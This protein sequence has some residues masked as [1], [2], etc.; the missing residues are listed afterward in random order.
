VISSISPA[1][2]P[3]EGGTLVTIFG[4]GFQAPMQVFFGDLEAI[5]VNV[6]NDTT[7]ANQD[8]ITC[9]APDY[10][11][12]NDVPPVTVDVRVINMNSG[13]SDS[14]SSF[15]YGDNL[16]ISGNTPTEGGPGTLL[17]I[18]GSGFEDPLHVDLLCTDNCG[19]EFRLEVVSV[20]GTEIVARIP[21]STPVTC[22]NIDVDIQVTLLDS[23]LVTI[24]GEFRYL[25]Q[26]PRIFGVSPVIFEEGAGGALTPDEMTIDGQFFNGQD[27]LTVKLGNY[28]VPSGNIE[29]TG[30]NR[31]NVQNMPDSTDI[32]TAFDQAACVTG[33]GE[34]GL[35]NTS[36]PVDITVTNLPG[37]CSDFEVA[38][39]VIEPNDTACSVI[40]LP[41]INVTF[42]GTFPDTDFGS[43]SSQSLIIANEGNAALT[44]VV[45]IDPL[46]PFF[47]TE[48]AGPPVKQV[49]INIPATTVKLDLVVVFDPPA[50][51]GASYNGT[52]SIATNDPDEGLI[53]E[54]LTG[55]E[56]EPAPPGP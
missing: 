13:L 27:R 26:Q 17:V 35:R 43:F 19:V 54:N 46:S 3:L 48:N 53:I 33:A 42:N 36:T 16:Y 4:S 30:S 56:N 41:D 40:A 11:Q 39:F 55:T 47:L 23:N 49:A 20:S 31:I 37:N 21:Q 6:F 52:L 38:A 24:G 14:Y 2:G 5:N 50:D 22:Q 1:A 44:G 32:I 10:S 15:T 12:Q 8:R 45:S 7:P 18:Y 51:G 25:G 34:T 29:V 28:T 9:V